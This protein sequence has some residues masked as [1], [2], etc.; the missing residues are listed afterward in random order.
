MAGVQLDLFDQLPP[1]DVSGDQQ[2]PGRPLW[3]CRK[4][5]VWV[6]DPAELQDGR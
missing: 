1:P 3:Y 2:F 6:L 4:R 5:L